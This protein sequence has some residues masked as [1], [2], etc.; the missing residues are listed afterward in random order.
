MTNSKMFYQVAMPEP[1]SHLFE[2]TLKI[3]NWN[4]QVLDLKMPV[5]TPGSYLVREYSK[6]V[7]DFQAKSTSNNQSLVSRKLAKNHWQVIT[8]NQTEITEKYCFNQQ[9]YYF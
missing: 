8:D 9:F 5:W 4:K 6:H 3:S 2:V 1:T 7:Q